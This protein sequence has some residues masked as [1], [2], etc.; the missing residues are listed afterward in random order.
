MKPIVVIGSINQ[1]TIIRVV[2]LPS[3][4]ETVLGSTLEMRPGGKGANQA[5]A[6]SLLGGQVFLV[7]MVGDDSTGRQMIAQ[8]ASK[9][10]DVSMVTAAP[11]Q[12][13][14]I[15]TILVDD[16]GENMIAVV[17]GANSMVS[18]VHVKLAVGALAVEGGVAVAQMEVPEDTVMAAVQLLREM[19]GVVTVLNP[20]PV[21][22][23]SPE[24]FHGVDILVVNEVEAGQLAASTRTIES[25]SQA[26]DAAAI[27]ASYDIRTVIVTLGRLGAV[28]YDGGDVIA[29]EPPQVEAVDTTGAGDAFVGA[30][31]VGV[32]SG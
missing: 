27:I 9:G 4:G 8:I 7:G 3:P 17:P 2:D 21:S 15:A 10:V 31:S 30:L 22:T 28:M 11:G 6:A 14:G 1:D 5:V 18:D 25:H 23:A 12:L 20:S 29:V 16:H 26:L 19:E 24:I 13:T 32:S